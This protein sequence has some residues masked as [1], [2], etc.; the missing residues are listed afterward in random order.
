MAETESAPIPPA[1]GASALAPLQHSV[2]RRVW[3]AST[4]A[5]LGGLIQSVGA[6]WMMLSI[7]Q[8]ADMVA[9]VQTS[10]TLPIVLLSLIAGATADNLDRRTMM[11]GA[12]FFMLI[13]SAA[14]AVCAWIGLITPWLLLLFTFLIGCGLAFNAPAWQAS[15]GDMVPRRDLPGA[16]ALASM[17]FNIARS[18]GPALGGAIVAAVGAAAAFGVNAVSYVPLLVVLARWR[19]PAN[20]RLLPREAL[21][22]AVAAGVR[23]VAMSPMI[24]AVLVRALVFCIGAGSVMALLPLV[25]KVLIGGGPL[26]YGLLLGSFGAGAVAG[27]MGSAR[28]RAML[29]TETIVRSAS[30]AFAIAT[31]IAALSPYLLVT[32]AVLFV[33]GAG[34]LLALSTFNASV[35]MSAPRWVVARALSIYQMAAFAGLAGGSWL[36]G[37]VAE[38][39]SLTVA[40]LASSLV[41]F[42]CVVLGRWRPLVQAEE[43]N[44]DP[45]RRWQEP[46]TVLPIK[47]RSGPIV[48]TI[49]YVIRD[50]DVVEFLSAMTERRRIRRRDGARNWRLLRDL[51]D[52]Q[53]WIERYETPT[54]IEYVRHNSRMTHHDAVVPERLRALHQGPEGPR[55]RRMIERQSTSVPTDDSSHERAAT[56]LDPTR[57]S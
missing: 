23:Y 3:F 14:L 13:V 8:S 10:M 26:I 50:E 32:M 12:Q 56:L 42:G 51:S 18:L 37:A 38:S 54:W 4:L 57:V 35:Q 15:V 43:L 33:A 45:L 44:L 6:S 21:G 27:A 16:V 20:P 36:W 1:P 49:E 53:R 48:V 2:F 46:K 5:N 25:A 55:V 34:W 22:V 17:G 9:L 11:L 7:A 52:P 47:Q 31:A 28:L 30:A 41:T 19:P 40:L 39:A 29:S 24:C